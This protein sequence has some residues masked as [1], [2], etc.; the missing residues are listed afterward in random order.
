MKRPRIKEPRLGSS[1]ALGPGAEQPDHELG[2]GIEGALG[3][4]SSRDAFAGAQGGLQY[5]VL[6]A[7]D[8]ELSDRLPLL[9]RGWY[10][11]G[12]DDTRDELL[13]YPARDQQP[14][15]PFA[16]ER[17]FALLPAIELGLADRLAFGEQQPGLE[18]AKTPFE[19]LARLVGALL[20]RLE[21]VH[22]HDQAKPVLHG[23]ADQAIA[24][25]LGV[26]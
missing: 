13:V 19:Q 26:P 2:G 4:I 9:D 10:R 8:L 20:Q 7:P 1:Y 17:H 25:L 14:D 18:R 11:P 5:D 12:I 15:C 23:R 6:P 3:H 22:H 24:C 21:A 16:D